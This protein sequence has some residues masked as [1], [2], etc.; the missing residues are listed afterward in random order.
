MTYICISKLG[1]HL[2]IQC[3]GAY[4]TPNIIWNNGGLLLGTDL[5]MKHFHW[6]KLIQTCL[7]RNDAILSRLQQHKTMHAL[8]VVEKKY[9]D[10]LWKWFI[11]NFGHS[12][13]NAKYLQLILVHDVK[14]ES[15]LLK[16]AHIFPSH[17][18][19][20]STTISGIW[21]SS[22]GVI[23]CFALYCKNQYPVLITK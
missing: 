23:S 19:T 10:F 3:L 15:L 22:G 14:V 9:I 20:Q 5:K 6:W 4:S 16:L 18:I 17:F 21:S 7:Q 11:I 1:H 2:F 8:D 12:L 13:E